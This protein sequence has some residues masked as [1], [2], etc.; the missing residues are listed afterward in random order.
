MVRKPE[1]ANGAYHG[2]KEVGGHKPIPAR[3][4]KLER[5]HSSPSDC[6]SPERSG[7]RLIE[8]IQFSFRLERA[9]DTPPA[10]PCTP[11]PSPPPKHPTHSD[12][13]WQVKKILEQRSRASEGVGT[14]LRQPLAPRPHRPS[15]DARAYSYLSLSTEQLTLRP[16]SK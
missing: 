7:R 14:P 8:K 10:G 3:K 15:P 2:K 12:D 4:R 6:I 16:C 11:P 5:G 13:M 9:Y 1:G